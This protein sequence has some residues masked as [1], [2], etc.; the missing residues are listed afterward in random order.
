[1]KNVKSIQPK[2]RHTKRQ[3]CKKNEYYC[4]LSSKEEDERKIEWDR[5]I[6][7]NETCIYNTRTAH[8]HRTHTQYTH[9]PKSCS[10]RWMKKYLQKKNMRQTIRCYAGCYSLLPIA[11]DQSVFIELVPFESI[12]VV[13]RQWNAFVR[14]QHINYK[15]YGMSVEYIRL[16]SSTYGIHIFI[17]YLHSCTELIRHYISTQTKWSAWR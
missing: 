5:L 17:Y 3:N 8:T 2:I 9:T 11:T 12:L 14:I 4:Y 15:A 10:M 13:D 16:L 7:S 1:M 6:H